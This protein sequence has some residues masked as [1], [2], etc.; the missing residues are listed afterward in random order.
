MSGAAHKPIYSIATDDASLERLG[1][2]MLALGER[3]DWI[4]EAEHQDDLPEMAQRARALSKEAAGLGLPPLAEAAERVAERSA[5][6]TRESLHEA[7]VELTEVARRV[8][9]GVGG[10]L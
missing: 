1:G 10:S 2:F 5:D 4:Q 6:A 8:A 3:I 7:I 9:L